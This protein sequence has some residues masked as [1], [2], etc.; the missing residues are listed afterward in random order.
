[1]SRCY[2]SI[3]RCAVV[4][5]ELPYDGLENNTQ[6]TIYWL[7]RRTE[8]NVKQTEK[9]CSTLWRHTL[10]HRHPHP[11]PFTCH[12]LLQN[13]ICFCKRERKK[14]LT[15]PSHFMFRSSDSISSH[16]PFGLTPLSVPFSYI[17]HLS[18]VTVSA[19]STQSSMAPNSY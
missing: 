6:I 4:E 5:D 7:S 9:V 12:R 3:K 13:Y 1:M 17:N 18:G 8:C 19:T 10:E 14:C 11:L 16:S 2:T 15:F